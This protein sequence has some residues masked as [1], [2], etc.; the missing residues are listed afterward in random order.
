[1]IK[2][3]SRLVENNKEKPTYLAFFV[4]PRAKWNFDVYFLIGNYTWMF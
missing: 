2:I 1:M 3:I 4:I